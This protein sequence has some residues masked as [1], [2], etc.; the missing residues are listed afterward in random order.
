MSAGC[1]GDDQPHPASL[2]LTGLRAAQEPLSRC[3]QTSNLLSRSSGG[4]VV[5]T[6]LTEEEL[7]S[8][9]S[10]ME[11]RVCGVCTSVCVR[12]CVYVGVRCVCACEPAAASASVDP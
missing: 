7:E 9:G 4:T 3:L 8:Q 6:A 1:L 10:G 2:M 12:G 5:V 11:A